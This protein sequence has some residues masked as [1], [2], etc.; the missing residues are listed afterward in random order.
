[1]S[2]NSN[3]NILVLGGAGFIGSHLCEA[4][5]QKGNNVVCVDNFI[6]SNVENIRRLL[7]YPSF[8]FIRHDV[9][10]KIDLTSLPGLK[11]FKISPSVFIPSTTT[12]IKT[13]NPAI[14]ET[15]RALSN[16]S[17]PI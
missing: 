16:R 5:V 12:A 14:R 11:K 15:T 1:M 8:A 10:E 3:K 7:Q 17:A 2:N 9:T 6:S 4:L 13:N